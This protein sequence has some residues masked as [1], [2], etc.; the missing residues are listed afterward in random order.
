LQ[1]LLAF[2]VSSN[3]EIIICYSLRLI[4]LLLNEFYQ[5]ICFS[6]LKA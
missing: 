1:N 3:Y 4:M 2:N 6:F 5:M